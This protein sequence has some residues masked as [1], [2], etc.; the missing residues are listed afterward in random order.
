MSKEDRGKVTDTQKIKKAQEELDEIE[1]HD[2]FKGD[3]YYTCSDGTMV[4]YRGITKV[5]RVQ[6]MHLQEEEI[7]EVLD[8]NATYRSLASKRMMLRR[9]VAHEP[10]FQKNQDWEKCKERSQELLDLFGKMY[11]GAE[12]H[13]IVTVEWGYSRVLYD[14]HILQFQR[15]NIDTITKLKDEYQKNVSNVRLVHKRS[16]LDELTYL[17]QTRKMKYEHSQQK[18]DHELMLKTL[19]Q[20]RREV[21]GQRI[22]INGQIQVEHEL[23]VQDHVNSEILK[24]L[25]I[26][27]II[28]GRLCSRLGVNPKYILY[29][30]HTSYYSK[31]TGFLPDSMGEENEVTYP[32]QIVYDFNRIAKLNESLITEDIEYKE[33]NEITDEPKALSIKELLSQKLKEKQDKI[34]AQKFNINNIEGK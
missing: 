30:L 18:T 7:Q 34:D 20:I 32:S 11:S 13:K 21:E 28:I 26:N 1:K 19:E 33:E 10:L 3:G 4:S 23:A 29:R 14:E 15:D 12:I 8:I 27:D 25:N 5:I 2:L 17:Y 24:Y 16:R 22:T 9:I 31:F 6:M